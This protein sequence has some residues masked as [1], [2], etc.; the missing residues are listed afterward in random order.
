MR[1]G[2]YN[3]KT[4]EIDGH[5]FAS[6]GEARRY[7]ELR[8]LERADKIRDLELQP[9]FCLQDAFTDNAGKRHRS[10]TYVADFRYYDAEIG[11]WAVE[12]YKGFETDV[13]CIKRKLFQCKFPDYVFRVTK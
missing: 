4:V 7:A 2:K 3:A 10:I 6:Q 9:G 11:A 13:F 1:R 8:L 12:D 5:R